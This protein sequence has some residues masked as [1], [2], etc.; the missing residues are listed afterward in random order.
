MAQMGPGRELSY[1][2][3]RRSLRIWPLEGESEDELR[4]SFKSF[5]REALK[6]SAHDIQGMEVD[7]IR[8]TCTSPSANAY[9]EACVTFREMDDRDFVASRST[10]LGSLIK[11]DGQL[12]A[13]IRLDVPG[14]LLP[15]FRDLNSYAY[16]VRRTHGKKTRTHIKFDDS[17][18]SLLLEVRLP[19][20]ENWLRISPA[21]PAN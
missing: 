14:F 1:N 17:C 8:R 13:G 10:N 11:S 18:V 6:V 4:G 2:T 16:N 19:S 12:M 15:T 9:M 21:A 3:S 20:S 7:R 5:A